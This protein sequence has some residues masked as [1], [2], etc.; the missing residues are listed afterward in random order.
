MFFF[1]RSFVTNKSQLP[2]QIR[3]SRVSRICFRHSTQFR[4]LC[5]FRCAFKF[6][7]P[8]IYLFIW[9]RVNW[10]SVFHCSVAFRRFLEYSPPP[11]R[12]FCL[13]ISFAYWHLPF[14]HIKWSYHF[15]HTSVCRFFIVSSYSTSW[16]TKAN[17]FPFFFRFFDGAPLARKKLLVYQVNL[18]TT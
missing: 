6:F 7:I 1:F 15:F 18:I 2:M 13:N 12:W 8:T 9:E 10:Q 3:F 17:D 16:A 11:S 4:A 5:K 14:L